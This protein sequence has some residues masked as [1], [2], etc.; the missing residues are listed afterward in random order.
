MLF[1]LRGRASGTSGDGSHY[2]GGVPWDVTDL[3]AAVR[4]LRYNADSLPGS[5]DR[6]FTFGH[7]S[8]GAQSALMGAT[9]D[10]RGY[11][12]YLDAIGAVLT[13]RSSSREAPAPRPPSSRP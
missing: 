1:D 13:D 5:M 9:G 11:Q 2:D 12:V 8:G 6:I 10:V 3:K 4:Y 7:S